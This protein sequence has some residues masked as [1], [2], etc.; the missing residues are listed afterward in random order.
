MEEPV[1]TAAPPLSPLCRFRRCRGSGTSK[2]RQRQEGGSSSST[3]GGAAREGGMCLGSL[4]QWTGVEE[5]GMGGTEK[6]GGGGGGRGHKG[7]G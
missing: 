7:G 2:R 1:V 3:K 5:R 6:G 4:G